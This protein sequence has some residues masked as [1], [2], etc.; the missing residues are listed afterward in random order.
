M[1]SRPSQVLTHSRLACFRA[2]PRRHFLRYELGL[3]PEDTGF[4]LR[5]GSAFHRALDAAGKGQDPEAAIA[6]GLD[7]PF[8]LALVAAMFDGHQRRWADER[9]EVVAEIPVTRS[10]SKLRKALEGALRK[11]PDAVKA[12]RAAEKEHRQAIAEAKRLEKQDELDEAVKVIDRVRFGDVRVT[13]SWEKAC[14]YGMLLAR[15]AERAME[16]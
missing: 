15:K 1:T 2:C 10:G 13:K 8:D 7:D 12:L 9:L 5:V 4:A 6:D 16:R 11:F 3:R 14:S